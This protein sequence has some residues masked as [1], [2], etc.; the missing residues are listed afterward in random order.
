MLLNHTNGLLLLL[1]TWIIEIV[2]EEYIVIINRMVQLLFLISLL[3]F[4]IT[5]VIN[6]VYLLTCIVKWMVRL[7]LRCHCISKWVTHHLRRTSLNFSIK[8]VRLTNRTFIDL[9]R[10]EFWHILLLRLHYITIH[11]EILMINVRHLLVL[12]SLRHHLHVMLVES[13]SLMSWILS[14]KTIHHRLWLL[15]LCIM[16]S[17]VNHLNRKTL[18]RHRL[19]F[20]FWR[21]GRIFEGSIVRMIIK[22]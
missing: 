13:G 19:S 22:C 15:R 20:S 12:S 3:V 14:M 21:E 5:V 11:I 10:L 7:Y 16:L 1:I 4:L 18:L 17:K 8:H 9:H 6:I 2:T